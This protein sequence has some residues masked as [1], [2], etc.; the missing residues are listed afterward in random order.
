MFRIGY[1]KKQP[2]LQRFRQLCFHLSTDRPAKGQELVTNVIICIGVKICSKLFFHKKTRW[3]ED[4][5]IKR[6]GN[7]QKLTKTLLSTKVC[8]GKVQLGSPLEKGDLDV[9]ALRGVQLGS[10]HK[11]FLPAELALTFNAHWTFLETRSDWHVFIGIYTKKF[12]KLWF[13]VN[14][15][16]IKHMT[17]TDSQEYPWGRLSWK[18]SFAPHLQRPTFKFWTKWFSANASGA[19]RTKSGLSRRIKQQKQ[20]SHYAIIRI[21]CGRTKLAY[22]E[23]NMSVYTRKAI[24]EG[25]SGKTYTRRGQRYQQKCLSLELKHGSQLLWKWSLVFKVGISTNWG[26]APDHIHIF[27]RSKIVS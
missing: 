20:Y 10:S 12:R 8:L 1:G 14:A 19:L 15:E 7:F 24:A 26:T 4:H 25:R 21:E 23:L 27:S 5:T 3:N 18:L 9:Q 13:Q 2:A 11:S 16:V 17:K 6:I 22:K